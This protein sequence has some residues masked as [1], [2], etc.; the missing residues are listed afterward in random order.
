LLRSSTGAKAKGASN[1]LCLGDM[2]V[3]P[4]RIGPYEVE[5]LL[6]E[7]GVG[8]VYAARDTLLGRR[9]AIKTLRPEMAR[10]RNLI[11]RFYV[12]AKSLANLNH[13]N[14]TTLYALQMEAQEACMVMELINGCTLNDLLARVHRLSLRESLAVAAQAVAGLRYAHRRGVIHRD[15]KPSNLMVTD[16]GVLKIMDFGVARVLGAQQLTR[17]GEFYGTIAYASPEQIRADPID[18]RSD[19][20]SLA[21]VLYRLLAGTPP[22]KADSDYAL[23]TAHLETP[24]PPLGERVPELDHDTEA[25]LIRALA[26]QPSDRF[27]SIEEFGRAVGAHALR[28]ES[29]DILQQL[30]AEVF[31]DPKSDATRVVEKRTAPE[32]ESE[33]GPIAARQRTGS[34]PR[35][36]EAVSTGAAPHLSRRHSAVKPAVLAAVGAAIAILAI[37]LGTSLLWPN[38]TPS[39][40]PAEAP[41]TVVAAPV[42]PSER[43]LPEAATAATSPPAAP[44]PAT[45]TAAANREPEAASQPSAT[46]SAQLPATSSPDVSAAPSPAP[47]ATPPTPTIATIEPAK[48]PAAAERSG[49]LP[50]LEALSPAEDEAAWS[51]EDKREVQ[52]ALRTL[53]HSPDEPDGNFA[54]RTR[55]AIKQFQSFAGEPESGILS[56]AQ[57]TMLLDMAQRL[58]A[59]LETPQTSPKGVA[60]AAIKGGPQRYARAWSFETGK[61]NRPDPAEAAY[62]YRLAAADDEAKALTN[63]GTLI[64][65]GQGIANPDPEAARL[66]W[67]AA[68]ARSEAIAMFN[69]GAMYERGIGVTADSDA[70]RKWYE[71]AAAHDHPQARAALKRLGAG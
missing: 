65:R 12:E 8:Q 59:L 48:P 58:T 40:A 43:P 47:L 66:L 34:E 44:P 70:A 14:I 57:R 27:A 62:W 32:P 20:Y 11:E 60:A 61:G 22:F 7:G 25:A 46:G 4:R 36:A 37:G 19:V 49:S 53:G 2:D 24:P 69:L 31:Q 15:I 13:T 16:E 56:A 38:P 10:D 1:R 39:H 67:W 42:A 26:K 18:E 17:T 33:S 68:A 29:V 21:I 51:A 45:T 52:R 54:P 63:L 9:V 50:R 5:E 55:A 64:A 3:T 6:G 41:S 71:R 23:M 35:R 28:G 30:Y